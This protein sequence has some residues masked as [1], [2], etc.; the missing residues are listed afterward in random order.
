MNQR[1]RH[2]L[3]RHRRRGRSVKMIDACYAAHVVRVPW[4][5]LAGVESE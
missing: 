2:R 5:Y 3:Q 4:S 1:I